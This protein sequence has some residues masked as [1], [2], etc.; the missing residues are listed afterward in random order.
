MICVYIYMYVFVY[1]MYESEE[2]DE[3]GPLRTKAR[4]FKTLLEYGEVPEYIAAEYTRATHCFSLGVFLR[5]RHKEET[6]TSRHDD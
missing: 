4:K 3:E 1:G 2:P 5:R 6:F